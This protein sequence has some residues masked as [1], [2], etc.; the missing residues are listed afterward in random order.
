MPIYLIVATCT[1]VH[2][3]FGGAKV[4][5]PLHALQLGIDVFTV[6][7]I[8]A[9]CA[10]APMMIAL[11]VGRLVDR[12]GPRV[13][14]LCG[15]AGVALALLIPFAFTGLVALCAMAILVGTAFQF[16]FVPTQGITGALGQPEERARNYSLLALGFSIASFLGPLL[17]GYSIDYLGYRAAYLV[18]AAGPVCAALLLWRRGALLPRAAAAGGGEGRG[19]SFGLLRDPRLR[20]AMVASA[21]ISIGWDLYQF[22]FPIY[23]HAIG[24]SPSTIG[25]VISTFALA[26]FAIRL[27][28]PYLARR[29]AEFELLLYGI[30]FSGMALLLFPLFRDPWLLALASFVLGLGCGVGQPM[31]MSLIYSLSPPGRASE[32]AAL[33]IMFNHGTHLFVPI[34]FGGVGTLMGFAPVFVSCS[35]LLLGGSGYGLWA[36]WREEK[37][38]RREA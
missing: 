35:A 15:A 31:S 33:R 10:L 22:Y 28:L 17:A 23:G 2:A 4:A 1:L 19:S 13:P 27:A 32:G 5:I 8:M 21:L 36:E 11:Y 24:L 7:I 38:A 6:G 9:A 34:A 37:T 30:A 29:W 14:M 20:E 26:V 16:F 18:L 3:G 25:T 12:V